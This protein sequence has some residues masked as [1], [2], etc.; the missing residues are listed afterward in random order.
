MSDGRNKDR[1]CGRTDKMENIY[2]NA[3]KHKK[4][5]KINITKT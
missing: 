3:S 4:K 5:N 2:K 1:M